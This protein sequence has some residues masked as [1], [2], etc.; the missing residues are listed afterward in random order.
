[1]SLINACRQVLCLFRSGKTHLR[2]FPSQER[3]LLAYFWKNSSM[4]H[5]LSLYTFFFDSRRN[6]GA[7]GNKEV[8]MKAWKNRH[9]EMSFQMYYVTF[10]DIKWCVSPNCTFGA[11][12]KIAAG[13]TLCLQ[14]KGWKIED[15][16][17]SKDGWSGSVLPI[18]SW[19]IRWFQGILLR[20]VPS[21]KLTVRNWKWMVGILYSFLLGPGLFSVA[22]C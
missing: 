9:G 16:F 14:G 15:I 21:L 13:Q 12:K 5:P 4:F 17:G 11:N 18:S 8:F 1:M 6:E 22:S 3:D 20:W 7:E 19:E 2:F 10:T